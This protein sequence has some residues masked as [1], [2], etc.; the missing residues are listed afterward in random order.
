MDPVPFPGTDGKS[1]SGMDPKIGNIH[2]N[3]YYRLLEFSARNW[4]QQ[5]PVTPMNTLGPHHLILK[6]QKENQFI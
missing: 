1:Y 3:V 5:S 4:L 2:I 6:S